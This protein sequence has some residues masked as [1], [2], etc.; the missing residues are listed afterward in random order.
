MT[1]FYEDDDF[2]QAA[3]QQRDMERMAST[4][5]EA[6]TRCVGVSMTDEEVD[7]ILCLA[8]LNLP[9]PR[10]GTKYETDR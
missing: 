7:A 2:R 5:T 10:K 9:N 6:L 4:A 8:G 1:D 3:E